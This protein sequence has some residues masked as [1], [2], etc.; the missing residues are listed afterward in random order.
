MEVPPPLDQRGFCWDPYDSSSPTIQL[1]ETEPDEALLLG[2]NGLPLIRL[3]PRIGF[4][5]KPSRRPH[6]P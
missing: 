1:V 2:P 4:I 6:G 3:K 5:L